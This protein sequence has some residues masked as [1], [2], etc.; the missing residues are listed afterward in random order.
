MTVRRGKST[1]SVEFNL[2]K[3]MGGGSAEGGLL[4]EEKAAPVMQRQ[5]KRLQGA[6]TSEVLARA[7]G[8]EGERLL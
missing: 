2:V 7:G 1:C 4:L 5:G 8:G 6:E 3:L